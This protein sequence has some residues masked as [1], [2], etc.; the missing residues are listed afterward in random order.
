MKAIT[1][2]DDEV[3]LRQVS[4]PVDI[5]NDKELKENIEVLASYCDNNAVLAMAAVQLGIP[6]RM[7]YIRNTNLEVIKSWQENLITDEEEHK[8]NEKK[9]LINPV[10]IKRKGITEYWEACAS[11]LDNMGRVLRP[12]E[13]ELEYYDILGVKHNETYE[14]FESTVLSH[15]MDHLDGVLHMDVAEEVLN[16]PP[17]ERKEFRKTHDYEV[18]SKDGDYEKLKKEMRQVK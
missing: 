17:E 2:L 7:I 11:C 18:L 3:Y 13:I 10:I 15:E 12:Y 5:K 16:M 1:I 14:G 9:V 6:K 4:S 8:H